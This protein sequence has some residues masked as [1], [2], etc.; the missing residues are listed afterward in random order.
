MTAAGADISGKITAKEG[1]I[2]GWKIGATTLT[3]GSLVLNSEGSIQ[4]GNTKITA[5]GFIAANGEAYP[6]PQQIRVFTGFGNGSWGKISF[7]NGLLV[8]YDDTVLGSSSQETSVFKYSVSTDSNF[9]I[10]ASGATW[11]V[12]YDKNSGTIGT[13]GEFTFKCTLKPP[14]TL[15]TKNS[16]QGSITQQGEAVDVYLEGADVYTEEVT[17]YTGWAITANSRTLYHADNPR[18]T[19]YYKAGSS[20]SYDKYTEYCNTSSQITGTIK[21]DLQT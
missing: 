5:D 13:D 20:F 6:S 21:I 14:Q 15:Y 18:T 4:V 9:K 10:G 2:G 19:R 11:T 12:S 7:Y 1:E 3:G 8:S 17:N 16:S